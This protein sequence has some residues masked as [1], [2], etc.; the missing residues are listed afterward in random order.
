MAFFFDVKQLGISQGSIGSS[1]DTTNAARVRTT[2]RYAVDSMISKRVIVSAVATTGKALQYDICGYTNSSTNTFAFDYYWYNVNTLESAD[3]FTIRNDPT[4]YYIRC[5]LKYADGSDITPEEIES[6]TIEIHDLWNAENGEYPQNYMIAEGYTLDSWVEPYPVMAWR[7]ANGESPHLAPTILK[8]TAL[9]FSLPYPYGYWRI[10]DSN[11][12]Y[13]Y[14]DLLHGVPRVVPPDPEPPTPPEPEYEEAI[15]MQYDIYCDGQLMHSTVTPEK[16]WKVIDPVLDLQD[17]AAGSLEFT[18]PPF[19]C[20]YG[21]CQMMMSTISVRRNGVEIWEGRPVSF[22]EDMWLNHPITCE[23]ELAY[24]ND[25]YQ[26]Q[27]QLNNVT[28]QQIV[29]Y[30][31]DTYNARASA[32]RQFAVSYVEPDTKYESDLLNIT[33]PFQTTLETVNNICK[34]YGLH[35]YM[36]NVWTDGVKTRQV[37]FVNDSG[38]GENVTQTIEFGRNLVDYAK[39]YNF[40]SLVTYVLPLGA[41]SSKAGATV[42]DNDE[43]IDVKAAGFEQGTI[44]SSGDSEE[45][46]TNHTKRVRSK[47]YLT[48]PT[49]ADSIKVT[50]ESS[51]AVKV[52]IVVYKS[53]KTTQVLNSNWQNSGN[54]FDISELIGAAYYRVVIR[55]DNEATIEPSDITSCSVDIS[56]TRKGTPVGTNYG[57]GYVIWPSNK[58]DSEGNTHNAGDIV[59]LSGITDYGSTDEERNKHYVYEYTITEENAT[60]FVTTKMNNGAGMAV[61]HNGGNHYYIKK[62]GSSSVMTAWADF[63]FSGWYTGFTGTTKMYIAGYGTPPTVVNSKVVDKGLEEYVTVEGIST[64]PDQ[65]LDNVV[66]LYVR[67]TDA[68][69]YTNGVLPTDIYGRIEK[70]IEWSDVTDGATLYNNAIQYLRSDQFDGLQIELTA[71]DMSMLGFNATQLRCGELVMCKCD[72][73]G[74]YKA[75]P[76]TAIKIPLNKPED[77]KYTVGSKNKQNLTS[78]NNAT[79]SELLS[80]IAEKPSLSAVMSAAKSSAAEYIMDTNNGYVTMRYSESGHPEAIIISDTE[81]YRESP[82]GYWLFGKHGLGFILPNGGSEEEQAITNCAMT[83]DGKIVADMILAG[84]LLADLIKAGTLSLGYWLDEDGHT[85]ASGDLKVFDSHGFEIAHINA[86]GIMQ[87]EYVPNWET[88]GKYTRI[89]IHDGRI[90]F[91]RVHSSA[92]TVFIKGDGIIEDME[93][94]ATMEIYAGDIDNEGEI[95]YNGTSVLGLAVGAI[96]VTDSEGLYGTGKTNVINI[97]NNRYSFTKGI[98]TGVYNDGESLPTTTFDTADGKRVTVTDGLITAVENIPSNNE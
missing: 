62:A 76:V 65:S 21:K 44:T 73:Y 81:D 20:M 66:G 35:V 47:V 54:T 24:L 80:M 25:I 92:A 83:S 40:S 98:L 77:C 29:Q 30:V 89:D 72:P 50:A 7:A 55:Y 91:T 23:G 51:A 3:S 33:I 2:G 38:L 78:V 28:L 63:K 1:G 97:R 11:N 5:I 22:K 39:S 9:A 37:K 18:L 69:H 17:S 68:S 58:K 59:S 36:D 46:D 32:N 61:V 15:T 41:K 75:M 13:P 60:V 6:W 88:S 10:D 16:E 87:Q 53:D 43:T 26:P 52:A 12:G 82:T 74:L 90:D 45:G 64:N 27:N 31:F 71:L 93:N 56:K 14:T 67:D 4:A 86:T 57:K 42:K 94:W 96:A 85:H 8:E 70:K 84:T 49:G 95:H 34:T 79:N 48:M 19:N